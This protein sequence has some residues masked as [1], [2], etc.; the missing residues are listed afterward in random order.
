MNTE[1]PSSNEDKEAWCKLGD[2]LEKQFVVRMFDT[3][4]SVFRNPAKATDP[5]AN[6]VYAVMQADIKSIRTPFRTADRYGIDPEFAITINEKDLKRYKEKYP[7]IIIFLDIDYPSYKG[8]RLATLGLLRRFV[9]MGMAKK[10]EYLNRQND[11]QGNAKASY[12]FDLRWF[13]KVL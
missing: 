12:V 13:D 3:G 6:D 5:F 8:V 1:T 10:H 9:K 7:N 11:T 2:E 4:L